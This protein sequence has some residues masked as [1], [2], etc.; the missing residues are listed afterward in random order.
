MVYGLSITS[1]IALLFLISTSVRA[2]DLPGLTVEDEIRAGNALLA[3]FAESQGFR[4]TP[5]NKRLE[6]YL[7][8]VGGKVA[9]HAKRKLPY[10]FHLDPH[11]AFRSAVA[12]PG[13]QIVVG[14]GVLA[15]MTHEDE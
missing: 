15:L 7:Q 8:V 14:G 4:D 5:Q 6:Q 3:S 12:Y 10:T 11:P 2:Q 1:T 9:A 13:G